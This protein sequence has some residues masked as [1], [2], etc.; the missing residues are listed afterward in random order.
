M[1]SLSL[2]KRVASWGRLWRLRFLL[3][4][5]AFSDKS[6]QFSSREPQ[7]GP[8]RQQ[9]N[10][11]LSWDRELMILKQVCAKG[12]QER[13]A[14]SIHSE[15]DPWSGPSLS[16]KER[17]AWLSWGDF[18]CYFLGCPFLVPQRKW[19]FLLKQINFF[20]QRSLEK[21][22]CRARSWIWDASSYQRKL[23]LETSMRITSQRRT[24]LWS[25]AWN[26]S[27]PS[28]TWPTGPHLPF[29]LWLP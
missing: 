10:K 2:C 29:G 13:K 11:T 15:L 23:F 27:E 3:G 21:C 16:F 20:P 9:C 12:M 24:A 18:S 5:P 26:I 14:G 6:G 1:L 19:G 28:I 17:P 4:R 22:I 25:E 8:P 7:T